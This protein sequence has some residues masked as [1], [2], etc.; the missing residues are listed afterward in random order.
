VALRDA[1]QW[2][3]GQTVAVCERNGIAKDRVIL[4]TDGVGGNVPFIAAGCKAG[5]HYITRLAHY[6]LLADPKIQEH[7]NQAAWLRVP[8]SGSGPVRQAA[9]L[10]CVLLEPAPS[11]L[12]DNGETYAPVRTRVVVSR[13]ACD[14]EQTGASQAV[15]NWH[16]ELFG[17][18]LEAA[19]WPEVEVVAGYFARAGQ[20]NRFA[21][22]DHELGLD[23]IFS[24]S[25]PGQELA[26][27]VG[28]FVWNWRICK[29]MEIAQ[30][31]AELPPQRPIS[32]QSRRHYCYLAHQAAILE[33]S[34]HAAAPAWEVAGPTLLPAM[35]R[36]TLTHESNQMQT[37]VSV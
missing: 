8:S 35:L 37:S 9:D 6:Q 25:L 31:P 24:Y 16:Y 15:G 27:L 33:S 29:G 4:R 20:E 11:S 13:F 28:L 34:L 36:K 22:E 5:I 18:D 3:V 1:Y 17:T 32:P 12:C 26:M 21:Q 2:A 23:R 10:G 19:A 7:L 14:K 30:P